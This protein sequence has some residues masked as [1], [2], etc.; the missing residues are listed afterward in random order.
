[1]IAS[2][3]T[4]LDVHDIS[5]ALK[6]YGGAGFYVVTPLSDQQTLVKRIISH[7]TEGQGGAHHPKRRDALSLAR[8]T[9]TLDDACDAIAEIEGLP[10]ILV[11]TSAKNRQESLSFAN[12]REIMLKDVPVLLAF[13]TAWGLSE[14]MLSVAD[15]I[16]APIQTHTGYNH[17]SVR[18]AVAIVL[19]RLLGR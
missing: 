8:V 7:W 3:V 12:L 5:R 19:D 14:E 10:P 16:L 18:S 2:A 17:L 4:N 1:M 11:A 9:D 15:H 6:T 13:G